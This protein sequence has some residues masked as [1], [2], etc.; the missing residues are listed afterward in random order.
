MPPAPEAAPGW[1]AWLRVLLA[2]GVVAAAARYLLAQAPGFS[3]VDFYY[4]ALYARDLATDAAST[5]AARR[6]YFPGTYRFWQL[7]VPRGAALSAHQTAWALVLLANAAG[8][9]AVLGGATRRPLLAAG[10]FAAYVGLALRL[11]GGFMTSEAIASLAWLLGCGGAWALL[12]R[13]KPRAAAA[14]L[15]VGCGL[16]LF[17]KQQGGLLS[18]SAL[19]LVALGWRGAGRPRP[20]L[21]LGAGLLAGAAALL[22]FALLMAWEGSG[23]AGLRFGLQSAASYAAEA[24]LAANLASAYRDAEWL[25]WLVAAAGLVWLA[26]FASARLRGPQHNALHTTLGLALGA[27]AGSL[28]QFHKRNYGHYALLGLPAAVL[29]VGLALALLR[30]WV[31]AV[32]QRWGLGGAAQSRVGWSV[33]ALLVLLALWSPAPRRL[34][35]QAPFTTVAAVAPHEIYRPLCAHIRPGQRL[36]LLPSRENGLHWACGTHARGTTWGYTFNWQETPAG[37]IAELQRPE[38]TQVFVFAAAGAYEGRVFRSHDW[39]PFYA[40]LA[41]LGFTATDTSLSG[42]L[43]TR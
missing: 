30:G 42:V 2:A 34:L 41:R 10:A 20:A 33:A 21:V 1:A 31:G 32:A 23:V 15:G 25:L 22:T 27:F 3:G 7:A 37:Y 11:E 38:L 19:G 40:E 16:A 5:S 26:A 24:S 6:F 28:W 36:L 17:M 14:A 35:A 8:V 4:F 29:A 9:A 13:D 39:A 18:L 43:Y 12:Q